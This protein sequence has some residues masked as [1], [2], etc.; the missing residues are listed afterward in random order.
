[1]PSARCCLRRGAGNGPDPALLESSGEHKTVISEFVDLLRLAIPIFVTRVS[2]VFMKV[3]DTALLGHAGTRYLTDAALSDLWTSSTGVFVMSG[4]MSVFGSQAYGAN[5][6]QLVGVWLQVAYCVL[7][8]VMVPVAVCWSLTGVVLRAFGKDSQ[9]AGEA[10]YYALVLMACFPARIGFS[11]LSSFFMS[12]RI[13]KPGYTCATFGMVFNL[14]FGCIFVLGI[15]IPGFNGYGFWACP[16][17]TV[18]LEY[19]QLALLLVVFCKCQGLH[20]ECWPG[21]S[22]SHITRERVRRFLGQ[23]FPSALSL[24]SDFWR[25]AAIGVVADT[26]GPLNIAVWNA[27]YRICWISLTFLGSVGGAM[28]IKLG[29]NLGGGQAKD[30]KRVAAVGIGIA[31]CLAVMLGAVVVAIPRQIGTIFD[32]DPEI[33]DIFEEVRW[34][35]AAFIVTMNVGTMMEQVPVAVG[36]TS[37]VF[38]AGLAG[39]WVGQVPCVLLCVNFWRRDLVGLYTGVAAGYLLLGVLLGTAICTIDWEEAAREARERSEARAVAPTGTA[40]SNEAQGAGGGEK[41]NA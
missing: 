8:S 2:W 34:P 18:A 36:R 23:Y 37:T 13:L 26:T 25:V 9:T 5:N 1:M 33:L 27:S 10:G 31:V 12:Q 29:K 3:T 17:V 30:A 14:I 20:R 32:S 15:P 35:L 19:A 6:K 40:P 24:A 22:R 41:A 16:L 39:S 28:S 38:W 21:W 4:T 11:Q 7:F